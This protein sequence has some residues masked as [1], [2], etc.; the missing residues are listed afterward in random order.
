MLIYYSTIQEK[1]KN[2]NMLFFPFFTLVKN[3]SPFN[4]IL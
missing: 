2:M 3:Q 1:M 4:I